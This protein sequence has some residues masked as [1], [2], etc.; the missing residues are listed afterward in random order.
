MKINS[1]NLLPYAVLW[2]VLAIAVL[3]LVLYRRSVSSHEDDSIH[4]EGTVPVEQVSLAHRLAMIDR[5]GKSL[6]V[7]AVLYGLALAALYMYQ[8]WTTVPNY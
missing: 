5:W 3:F 4:L 2:G 7:V 8:V 1:V 6:T